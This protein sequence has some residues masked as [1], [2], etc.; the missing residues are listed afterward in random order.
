M[1]LATSFRSLET[2]A[3]T[4]ARTDPDAVAGALDRF[5]APVVGLC[6]TTYRTR[7]F[8]RPEHG[9]LRGPAKRDGVGVLASE[10]SVAGGRLRRR[11]KET[12]SGPYGLSGSTGSRSL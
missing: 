9:T 8:V 5:D 3:T 2:H 7:E 4:A 12:W 11:Q 1:G 10:A 6:E